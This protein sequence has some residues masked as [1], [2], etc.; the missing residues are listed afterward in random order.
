MRNWAGVSLL[1]LIAAAI[2]PAQAADPNSA[3]DDGPACSKLL[4]AKTAL[5]ADAHRRCII[6]IA[7]TYVDAEE[8]SIPPEKQLL[9]D[10][11]G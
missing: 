11:L 7:T 4:A 3:Y 6:A 8:N 10:A 2:A 5:P 1:A 9:A